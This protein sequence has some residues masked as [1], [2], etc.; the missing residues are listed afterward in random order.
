MIEL[1]KFKEILCLR[2]LPLQGKDPGSLDDLMG[3]S[4][5]T[6]ELQNILGF[7]IA[8]VLWSNH[9]SLPSQCSNEV[10]AIALSWRERQGRSRSTMSTFAQ[11][12]L[13]MDGP[14]NQSSRLS[15]TLGKADMQVNFTMA[16]AM[17]QRS[18]F[19]Q[20]YTFLIACAKDLRST[21]P[22]HEDREYLTVTTELV[23]CCN[24][25]NQ[26]E[27]GEAT[28][29]EALQHRYS[30]SATRNEIGY[31]Q[32]ALADSFIGQSKYSEADRVLQKVLASGYVS[33]Y[34]ATVASL[35]L[36]KVKRRLGV[37][38]VSAFTRDSVLRKALTDSSDSKDH[39]RD[40]CL[41]ELSCSISFTQQKTVENVAV[42]NPVLDAASAIVARQP[43]STSNW[44]TRILNEQIVDEFKGRTKEKQLHRQPPATRSLSTEDPQKSAPLHALFLWEG[45]INDI[46][47]PDILSLND[48]FVE[49]DHGKSP[50]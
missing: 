1:L 3:A 33:T 17:I 14:N 43:I 32:I 8:S 31:L 26:E 29:L 6:A 46:L 34:L 11:N 28:A 38:D 2:V 13:F 48:L 37:L 20:A 45:L 7:L 21:D 30:N 19:V 10:I 16:M 49:M 15:Y 50:H 44:R 4:F 47:D 25:L 35:R 42:A 9:I 24:I 22:V 27:K 36:N 23:K 39:V 12:L 40:E 18:H 5:E 41:E